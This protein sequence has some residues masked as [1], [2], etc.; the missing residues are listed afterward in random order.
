V[1]SVISHPIVP[2]SLACIA[3]REKI[4]PRLV[5]AGVLA[6]VIPDADV[7]GYRLGIPYGDLLGHRGFSHSLIFA[8]LLAGIGL[9]RWRSLGP[10]PLTVLG[11]LF[12]SAASHSFLD[13]A[14]NG[15]LG[16]AFFSPF[17]NER[18]FLPWRPIQVSYLSVSRFFTDRGWLV[19]RS[20]VIWVWLPF[21]AMGISGFLIR[22]GMK[23]SAQQ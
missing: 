14:T 12:L 1:P 8:A 18:F 19:L 2:I 17:S 11:F 22:R 9:L 4:P 5:W 13:A 23:R 3:G 16:I 21:L 10:N 20:E 15:G 6:S 7:I